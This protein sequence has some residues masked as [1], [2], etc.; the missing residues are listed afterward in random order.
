[1]KPQ[2][3]SYEAARSGDPLRIVSTY[4]CRSVLLGAGLYLVG[5]KNLVRDSMAASAAIQ[6]YVLYWSW[7]HR[8]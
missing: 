2:L 5:N 7:R 8:E 6:A 3:P 4:L 1:M